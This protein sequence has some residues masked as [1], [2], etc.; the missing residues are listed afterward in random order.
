MIYVACVKDPSLER[1]MVN[2]HLL[3]SATLWKVI[4]SAS[5]DSESQSRLLQVDIYSSLL[6][7]KN[8]SHVSILPIYV[9]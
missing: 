5:V 9:V 1:D 3:A 2:G 4:G 6:T 8:L 7:Y